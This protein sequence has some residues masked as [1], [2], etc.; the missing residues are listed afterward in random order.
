MLV[1]HEI[2]TSARAAAPA[3]GRDAGSTTIL[4]RAPAHGLDAATV[5]L[6]DLVTPNEG[7]LGT[8]RHAAIEPDRMLVSLGAD[9]AE[10]RTAS[11]SV[12]IPAPRVE[13]VDTV[14][15]GDTLNGALAAALADGRPLE[16]DIMRAVI[17][18]SLAVT[19][20]GARDGMP[21]TAESEA[22]RGRWLR[23]SRSVGPG[24]GA[25]GDREDVDRERTEQ[26]GADD[27][28]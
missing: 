24:A 16:E 17:A 13:V 14:G 18:A 22:G 15:A 1:G 19:K 9:G 21:A 27:R 6:A 10:L 25:D 20:R 3:G 12:R 23:V 7:E 26:R 4:N 11:G 8:L 28:T 5:R 2:A